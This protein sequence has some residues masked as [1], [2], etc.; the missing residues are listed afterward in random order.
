MLFSKS[1]LLVKLPENLCLNIIKD[2][3]AM[4]FDQAKS[5]NDSSMSL[6]K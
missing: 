5:F 1:V 6:A 2:T 4:Y 3:F